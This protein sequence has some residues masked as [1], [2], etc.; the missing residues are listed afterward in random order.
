MEILLE[1]ENLKFTVDKDFNLKYL[2]PILQYVGWKLENYRWDD[3]NEFYHATRLVAQYQ[4]DPDLWFDTHLLLKDDSLIGVLLIT[5][6]KIRKLENRYEIADENQ[7]L[8]LKYFHVADKGKGYGTLW[9]N[10]VILPHYRQKNYRYL[11]VNSSHPASF[12]FYGRLGKQIAEYQQQSDN[13][14]FTR[15]GSCFMIRIQ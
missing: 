10:S 7:S 14:R 5:G 11:Y 2:T 4:S 9:I 12:L 3:Y 6:G 15:Q 13:D 8:L 1:K